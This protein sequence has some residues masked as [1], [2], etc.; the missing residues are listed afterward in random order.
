MSLSPSHGTHASA[1]CDPMGPCMRQAVNVLRL[2][3]HERGMARVGK[4]DGQPVAWHFGTSV[5][6]MTLGGQA[7]AWC[8]ARGKNPLSPWPGPLVWASKTLREQNLVNPRAQTATNV[9]IRSIPAGPLPVFD[10]ETYLSSVCTM[11][12]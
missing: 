2:G 3:V 5:N 7:Y 12:I 8:Q 11:E 10:S 6:I 1:S 4:C 9:V